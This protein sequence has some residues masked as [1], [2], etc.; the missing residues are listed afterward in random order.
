MKNLIKILSVMILWWSCLAVLSGSLVRA[1]TGWEG[2]TRVED[3]CSILTSQVVV[4]TA[5]A[6]NA[7]SLFS[8]SATRPCVKIQ[9]LDA[10]F[11]VA[12]GST[13]SVTLSNGFI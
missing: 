6:S 2:A 7:T 4:A 3:G 11:K 13:T 8:G 12:I 9:N 5:T 1:D 10:G